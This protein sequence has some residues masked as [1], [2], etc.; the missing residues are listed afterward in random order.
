LLLAGVAVSALAGAATG[1]LTY[2]ATDAQLRTITFWSMGSLGG[3][4][5]PALVGAAPCLL[6]AIVGLP[7][8]ARALDALALGEAE[9]AHLGFRVQRTK[10][11]VLALSALA[12]GAG[13]AVAGV[14]GFVGLVV[15]H[16]LRLILGPSQRGLLVGSSLLGASLLVLADDLAR[17]VVAPAELPLGLVTAAF[18]TPFFLGLLLRERRGWS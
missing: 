10:R 15:P 13:V 2:L 5:W 6:A 16:L 12:V 14:L 18:G 11:I 3:A 4:T 1:L 9:A 17:V 8:Q 7:W